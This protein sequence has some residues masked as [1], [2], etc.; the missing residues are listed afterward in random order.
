MNAFIKNDEAW[1][2]E[3]NKNKILDAENCV[4]AE[5]PKEAAEYINTHLNEYYPELDIVYIDRGTGRISIYGKPVLQDNVPILR[6][7]ELI[8][9]ETVSVKD[10]Y[11]FQVR[12][13][14]E[15]DTTLF[16]LGIIRNWNNLTYD[17]KQAKLKIRL[18]KRKPSPPRKHFIRMW[19]IETANL[20]IKLAINKALRAKAS[21]VY[22][23]TPRSYGNKTKILSCKEFFSLTK[24]FDSFFG[25]YSYRHILQFQ[26]LKNS[27]KKEKPKS[28]KSIGVTEEL[29][30]FMEQE[31]KKRKPRKKELKW[32]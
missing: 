32:N 16:E 26:E 18:S 5:T 31:I 29:F 27:W 13:K 20:Y 21:L 2:I 25:K 4:F 14:K 28:A 17:P 1:E 15:L 7:I 8:K 11:E 3:D 24:I 6:A 23:T 9:K 10:G 30:D 22:I 19:Q 12:V